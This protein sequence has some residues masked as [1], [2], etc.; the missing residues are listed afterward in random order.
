MAKVVVTLKLRE[1]IHSKLWD[2]AEKQGRLRVKQIEESG[3]FLY[4]MLWL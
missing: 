4:L 2:L 1:E 3:A